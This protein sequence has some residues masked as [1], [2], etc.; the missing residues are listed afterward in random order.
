MNFSWFTEIY[1]SHTS[2]SFPSSSNSNSSSDMET[3]GID[4][5]GIKREK[6][7]KS[8]KFKGTSSYKCQFCEKSF[9]R[10][11]YLK[12]HEQ[13]SELNYLPSSLHTRD[14]TQKSLIVN[15]SS[16]FIIAYAMK[17]YFFFLSW[18]RGQK[19]II[20]FRVPTKRFFCISHNCIKLSFWIIKSKLQ[21]QV[22]Y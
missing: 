8:A 1:S 5:E 14:I 15:F 10:L 22:A 20:I 19:I 13:V 17:F 3:N 16:L 18:R 11:G 6:K 7:D 9:P 2:I 21:V 4:D 12:K